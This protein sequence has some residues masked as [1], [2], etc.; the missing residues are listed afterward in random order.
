MK[1][2]KAT[3]RFSFVA[4]ALGCVLNVAHAG[5]QTGTGNVPCVG[6]TGDTIYGDNNTCSPTNPAAQPSVVFGSN[7]VMGGGGFG[8][9]NPYNFVLGNDNTVEQGIA[10]GEYNKATNGGL[11]IGYGSKAGSS[12]GAQAN[13]GISIFGGPNVTANQGEIYIG[14][15]DAAFRGLTA[16]VTS[17][18]AN[19]GNIVLNKNGISMQSAGLQY[20]LI[21]TSMDAVSGLA[22]SATM[23]LFQQGGTTLIQGVSNPVSGTD[24]ANKQYVDTAVAAVGSNPLDVQYSDSTKS[25]INL[26]NT[27]VKNAVAATADTDLATWG[28]AKNYA[29]TAVSNANSAMTNYVNTNLASTLSSAQNYTNTAATNTYNQAKNYTDAAIAGLSIPS[30]GITQAQ[31]DSAINGAITT[32]QNYTNTTATATYNQS[33]NY[34][35]TAIAG[36]STGGGVSQGYVDAGDAA[37]LAFSKS[38]TDQKKVE[39]VTESKSYT[40]AKSA[41]TLKSANDY[42]DQVGSNTLAAANKFTTDEISKL[43]LNGASTSYVDNAV[44]AGVQQAN[45]YTD[46]KFD[47]AKKYSYSA[48]ALGMAASSLVFDPRAARQIAI[49]GSTVNG[50]QAIA[51]GVAW[52]VGNNAMMNVKAGYAGKMGGASVG[53]TKAF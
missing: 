45:S 3:I 4:L 30:G 42:T 1:N 8:F 47:Q 36:L 24:A 17:P 37:T 46:Q 14:N 41:E 26:N 16:P 31:L 39:A 29:D 22:T 44:A 7:N 18:F 51:V 33:K 5:P 32:S 9:T 52:Q 28:Q 48:A 40:D 11:A 10:I 35:D 21:P 38:Y 15:G 20:S 6:V 13:G 34:T 49:A 27:Q 50:Q 12:F 19:V 53:Y 23:N 43:N 2:K 25:T